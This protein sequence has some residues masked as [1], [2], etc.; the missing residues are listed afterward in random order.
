MLMSLLSPSLFHLRREKRSFCTHIIDSLSDQY[1]RTC[2]TGICVFYARCWK[3]DHG[4]EDLDAI[5]ITGG[6]VTLDETGV[7]KP[8]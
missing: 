2:T 5:T 8:E 1:V 7:L 3:T 6:A 4:A